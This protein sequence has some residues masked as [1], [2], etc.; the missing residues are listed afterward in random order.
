LLTPDF[1]RCHFDDGDSLVEEVIQW[2]ENSGYRVGL[3]ETAPMPLNEA[4][5][6]L[7][8]KPQGSG[9]T[10][11]TWSMDYR[12]KYGPFGWL[13]GQTVMK[14]MMAKI[15]DG[16]LKGLADRVGSNQGSANHTS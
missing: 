4:Y 1:G 14:L 12:V 13:L 10:Q 7:S 5:A 11:V 3:S 8:I 16:N 15:L 9:R 2:Q 6:E